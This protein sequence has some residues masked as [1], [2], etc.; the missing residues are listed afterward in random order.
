MGAQLFI[1]IHADA[2]PQGDGARG[3]TIYTLSEVASDRR[4]RSSRRR[5]TGPMRSAAPAGAGAGVNRILIDLAQRESMEF[6][7]TSPS[8]AA[9]GVGLISPSAPTITASRRWWC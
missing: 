8:A 5:R 4:P 2:A 6:R 9:R 3:A 7:P 1:S